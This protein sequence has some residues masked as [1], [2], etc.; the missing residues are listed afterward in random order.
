MAANVQVLKHFETPRE[1]GVHYRLL[2]LTGENKG[3]SYF[4]KGKRV[5]MG[6]SETADIQVKDLKS[7][8]E[9]AEITRLLEDFIVTDL[10]S[11]NG[12]TV[13]DLKVKQ[14]KL[15]DGDKIIIGQTVY[16][17]GKVEKQKDEK[18]KLEEV[19]SPK[20]EVLNNS[21]EQPK[22]KM[23][24]VRIVLI[25]LVVVFLLIGDDEEGKKGE[26]DVKGS[27][28]LSGNSDDIEAVIRKKQLNQDRELKEKLDVIFQRGLRE[29]REGNYF[30]AMDEFNLALVISPN[31]HQATVYL[32][33][34]KD[35]LEK[36]VKT[37]FM[38]ARREMDSL[39]YKKATNSYCAIIRLL[40]NYPDH[41]DYVEA[42]KKIREIEEILQMEKNEIKCL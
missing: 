22:K 3:Q 2:C 12:I 13:N 39:K 31:D 6:R 15:K 40:H 9:H 7:S 26:S 42:E 14:H 32:Q 33:K 8:R 11:Q 24:P 30:R 25:I 10:G 28:N 5:V 21:F 4:L 29:Y 27:Y 1:P 20:T 23:N 18:P 16:K 38:H 34:T 19:K 35:A 37:Y 36:R 41:E 17:F